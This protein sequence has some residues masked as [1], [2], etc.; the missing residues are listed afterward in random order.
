MLAHFVGSPITRWLADG[1]SMQ[2]MEDFIFIDS[3][4]LEWVAPKGS[5]VDGASIPRFFWRYIGSP[6]VGKYRNGSVIHDVYCQTKSRPSKQV[7]KAFR[8]MMKVS[9]VSKYK[10]KKMYLAVKVGGPAW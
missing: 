2:L 6:F 8:E 9:G 1:R 10:A 7:H 3:K 4:G 5:I